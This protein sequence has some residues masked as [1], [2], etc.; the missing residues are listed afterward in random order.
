MCTTTATAPQK[1][2]FE[3]RM[4]KGADVVLEIDFQG[5]LQIKRDVS[6]MR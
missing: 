6:P 3:E 5:A 2:P 4:A 1:R